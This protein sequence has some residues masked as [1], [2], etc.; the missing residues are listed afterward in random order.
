ML[1]T[2]ETYDDR[3]ASSHDNQTCHAVSHSASKQI[4]SNFKDTFT[5]ITRRYKETSVAIRTI[6]LVLSENVFPVGHSG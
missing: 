5:V 2:Y 4:I 3:A 6:P 1:T